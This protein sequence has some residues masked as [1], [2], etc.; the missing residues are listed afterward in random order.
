MIEKCLNIGNYLRE[1]NKKRQI[2]NICEGS[3][4][5][6][7]KPDGKIVS[8][9]NGSSEGYKSDYRFNIGEMVLEEVERVKGPCDLVLEPNFIT[10]KRLNIDKNSIPTRVVTLKR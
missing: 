3:V 6:L 2:R 4:V 8:I 10:R 9:Y 1:W 7:R 5:S